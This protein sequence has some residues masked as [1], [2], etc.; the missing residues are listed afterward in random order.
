[1]T[2]ISFAQINHT[3][4]HAKFRSST[5]IHLNVRAMSIYVVVLSRLQHYVV[6]AARVIFLKSRNFKILTKK[7]LIS[8]RRLVVG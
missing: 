3:C 6:D 7:V 1:M 2:L 8:Q 5:T 4:V